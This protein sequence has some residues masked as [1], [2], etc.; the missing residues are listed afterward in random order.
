MREE[1]VASIRSSGRVVQVVLE[2]LDACS[3]RRPPSFAA[4]GCVRRQVT[5]FA[6]VAVHGD[7]VLGASADIFRLALLVMLPWLALALPNSMQGG[8]QTIDRGAS[9]ADDA[10]LRPERETGEVLGPVAGDD[11]HVVLAVSARARA[12]LRHLTG[13]IM[14]SIDTTIPGSSTVSTSSRS[15]SPASRP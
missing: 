13:L 10:V 7:L 4:P 9:G 6:R 2:F 3:S 11:E 8:P 1:D 14:G 12:P 5:P 15:S